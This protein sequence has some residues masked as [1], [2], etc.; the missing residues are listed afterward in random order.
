MSLSR[1]RLNR[2]KLNLGKLALGTR[3]LGMVTGEMV[4]RGMLPQGM[5]PQGMLTACTH[6]SLTRA[7]PWLTS[8]HSWPGAGPRWLW[9]PRALA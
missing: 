3:E 5:L 6:K 8:A 9:L 2:G 7:L 4:T 1:P